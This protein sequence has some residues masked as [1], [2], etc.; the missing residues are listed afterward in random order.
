MALSRHVL[1]PTQHMRH[2]QPDLLHRIPTLHH[3]Q[4]RQPEAGELRAHAT[5]LRR[6]ELE[7]RNRIAGVGIDAQ[8][9]HQRIRRVSRDAPARRIER[10]EPLIVAAAR[11]QRIVLV[12]ACALARARLVRVAEVERVFRLRV[13]VD[14][15]E[16]HI[17]AVV[18]DGLRAV[19]VVV[20]HIEDRHAR[21]AAVE[22]G[23]RGD[24]GIVDEAVAAEEIG[25][26]MVAGRT[27][28]GEGGARAFCNAPLRRQRHLRAQP[29]GL[30]GAGGE[31][32]AAV[33]GIQPQLRDEI[34]RLDIVPK[35]A[36][37]PHSGNRIARVAQRR[38]ALP[39]AFEETQVARRVH[40][41]DGRERE[42]LG[43]RNRAD[44]LVGDGLENVVGALGLFKAGDEFAAVE[45]E[46][47]AVEVVVGGVDDVH[48]END[49]A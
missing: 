20:V 33:V 32:R 2:I 27:A 21:R 43:C 25:A 16:Q 15:L 12:E 41:L 23:L 11:R 9:N 24:G 5:E 38:P 13:A 34:V 18:E 46:L 40:A 42:A 29:R 22:E 44:A 3:E 4:R 31:R 37:R 48:R 19:A 7:L 17:G 49:S 35:A 45:L 39:C 10:R 1:E 26:G 30:P 14:G 28:Q 8:R 6:V 47:A 36:D